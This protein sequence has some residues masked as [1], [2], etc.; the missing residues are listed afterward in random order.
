MLPS[1]AKTWEGLSVW[2][3]RSGGCMDRVVNGL[4]TEDRRCRLAI[5]VTHPIQYYSPWFAEIAKVADLTVFYAH[6][7]TAE[8]QAAAGFSSAFSW[9][10]P[11]LEGYRY[12]FLRN[13][14]RR[15]GVGHFLGVNP[16]LV[17]LVR[18]GDFDAVVTIGWN[19]LCYLQ[20]WWAALSARI[21][22]LVRLDSQ[23]GS[24]RA[25]WRRVIKRVLWRAVLPSIADYLS[26]GSR[27]D[28]Y[29]AHYGVPAER[30]HRVPHMVDV[31]RFASE[32]K[33]ARDAGVAA[34]MRRM[35]GADEETIVVLQ[36]GKLI[37]KKRPLTSLEAL[38]P[39]R[40]SIR[41][42]V[43]LWFAGDGPLEEV[44]AKQAAAD[45]LP[46]RQ[47]GFVNQSMLPSVYAAADILLLPST[48]DE[49]WGLVVNE[50]QACGLPVVVSEEVGMC[51]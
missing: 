3:S 6:K 36:V 46:V 43:Q 44:V 51:A 16:E 14:A 23:L 40:S 45:E 39:T 33:A 5:V 4:R 19:R 21:P 17:G 26:P 18:E 37:A 30:I 10:V 41:E 22:I 31:A 20:A 24:R 13:I 2:V 12:F 34:S 29:L 48:A 50:A 47:P 8:G 35:Y 1:L 38:T 28:A 9:D 11:L 32:A 42:R 15:P 49:T 25:L 27:S 7:Q